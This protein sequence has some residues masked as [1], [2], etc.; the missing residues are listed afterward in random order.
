MG[1]AAFDHALERCVPCQPDFWHSGGLL[2]KGPKF[3]WKTGDEA[4][5]F[6]S[7]VYTEF[8]AAYFFHE[9]LTLLLIDKLNWPECCYISHS[10]Q[11]LIRNR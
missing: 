7:R 5:D 2:L 9:N 8:M 3:P 1:W 10:R 6:P 11:I 4:T